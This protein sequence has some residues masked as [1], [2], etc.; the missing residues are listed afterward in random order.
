MTIEESDSRYSTTTSPVHRPGSVDESST[1]SPV[2]VNNNKVM[3]GGHENDDVGSKCSLATPYD[4]SISTAS[5]TRTIDMPPT[6][7]NATFDMDLT[8]ES[9]SLM[10]KKPWDKW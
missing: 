5:C 8:V 10:M 3:H 7:K 1:R 9:N 2:F 6:P 4:S